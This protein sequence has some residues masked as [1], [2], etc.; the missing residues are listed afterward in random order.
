MRDGNTT[1]YVIKS[2]IP[3]SSRKPVGVQRRVCTS[4]C[5]ARDAEGSVEHWV[6][7]E[8]GDAGQSCAGKRKVTL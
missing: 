1:Y 8:A 7:A 2:I 3:R 6:S 4:L 5:G